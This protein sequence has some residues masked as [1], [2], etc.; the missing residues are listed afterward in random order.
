MFFFT[1]RWLREG[2]HY[3]CMFPFRFWCGPFKAIMFF[4][5]LFTAIDGNAQRAIP[6]DNLAFPVL[7]TLGDDSSGSGFFLNDGNAVY[8][9]TAKHVLFKPELSRQI[10]PQQQDPLE[11]RSRNASLIS[12]SKDPTD[13]TKNLISLDLAALDMAGN[14]K[15]HPSQDVVVIKLARAVLPTAEIKA[16]GKSVQKCPIT[17]SNYQ[18]KFKN[19]PYSMSLP[20]SSKTLIRRLL[21]MM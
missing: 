9:V 3:L 5:F 11:L 6:D 20:T 4:S 18:P 2:I 1:F 16:D 10:T 7:I 17:R 8:L 13:T 19:W 12:Y 21:E 14:I 15:R